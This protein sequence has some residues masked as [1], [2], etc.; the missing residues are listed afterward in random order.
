LEVFEDIVSSIKAEGVLADYLLC[1]LFP[2]SLASRGTSWLRQ[3][4]PG[5]LTNWTDTKNA[6][7]NHFFDESVTEAI[8]LQI[9]LFTQAPAESLRA[10][11]LQFKSYQRECP[12]HG[13]Q[14]SQLIN[15]FY[16]GIDKPY[17]I[18][19]DAASSCNF[20]TR[21]TSEALILITNA[22]TGHSTQ[23]FDKERRISAEKATK[24]KETLIPEIS[25]PIQAPPLHPHQRPEWS[26]CLRSFLQ[27]SQSLIPNMNLSPQS[28]IANM[29]LSP[30]SLIATMILSPQI[31]IARLA[32]YAL[33]SPISHLHSLLSMQLHY[34]AESS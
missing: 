32:I 17:Q 31:S 26:L 33:N 19:L 34:A 7:M 27:A 23:E 5:S 18:Q 8:R 29:N 3:L 21:T 1:K 15:I 10:S 16:K 30:Q 14:E 13:F 6:F 11:W 25:A 2:H 24:S 20:M 9:S 12:Q 28:L 4:E 22:L